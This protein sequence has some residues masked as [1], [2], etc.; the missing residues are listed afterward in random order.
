M[1]VIRYKIIL[2]CYNDYK[3]C[4][5]IALMHT[6]NLKPS[7]PAQTQKT[8]GTK[9]SFAQMNSIRLKHKVDIFITCA[10][11]SFVKYLFVLLRENLNQDTVYFYITIFIFRLMSQGPCSIKYF[12]DGL[13]CTR[14]PSTCWP[15]NGLNI[16]RKTLSSVL[17]LRHVKT[18]FFHNFGHRDSIYN[19]TSWPN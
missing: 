7:F 11:I 16:S 13:F 15:Q 3:I 14:E 18:K 9:N 19:K 17:L 12:W 4:L 1:D 2:S 8:K 5:V 10:Y 6:W